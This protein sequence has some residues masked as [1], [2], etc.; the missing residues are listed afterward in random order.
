MK[1]FFRPWL[2]SDFIYY[3]TADGKH[4]AKDLKI[5]HG[6]TSRVIQ[7]RKKSRSSSSAKSASSSIDDDI[8]KKKRL[9]FLD[10]LLDASE[11]GNNLTTADLEQEVDTFMFEVIIL[12]HKWY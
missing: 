11:N 6:F 3:M 9:A 5:L 7:D 2:H 10:L 8:G 12:L 1:R 4:H